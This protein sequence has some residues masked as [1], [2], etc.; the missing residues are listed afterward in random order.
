MWEADVLPLELQNHLL[1]GKHWTSDLVDGVTHLDYA[2]RVVNPAV[3]VSLSMGSIHSMRADDSPASMLDI[4]PKRLSHVVQNAIVLFLI[5]CAIPIE[6]RP[7]F[8]R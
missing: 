3:T 1:Q 7:S 8:D 4:V 2:L 6:L 5:S